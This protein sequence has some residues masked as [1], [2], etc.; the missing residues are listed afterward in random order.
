MNFRPF[1]RNSISGRN[2]IEAKRLS[3]LFKYPLRPIQKIIDSFANLV[4]HCLIVAKIQLRES[5]EDLSG[6]NSER[7]FMC[8]AI[9]LH[10]LP[11]IALLQARS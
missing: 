5:S 10:T 6:E 7:N 8:E 11:K 3:T 4:L 2:A 9:A 1:A